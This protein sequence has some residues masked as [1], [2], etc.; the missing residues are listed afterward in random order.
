MAISLGINGNLRLAIMM[1]HEMTLLALVPV[2]E[3]T[4]PDALAAVVVLHLIRPGEREDDYIAIILNAT[5]CHME[6]YAGAQE[7]GLQFPNEFVD[8]NEDAFK[9]MES[10]MEQVNKERIKGASKPNKQ[11]HTKKKTPQLVCKRLETRQSLHKSPLGL[12]RSGE[13]RKV[14][15]LRRNQLSQL[16]FSKRT[17]SHPRQSHLM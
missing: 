15:I 1:S 8:D 6:L 7:K 2:D 10:A 16:Q 4:W 5:M 14:K 12:S 17:T 3:E 13:H 9:T 11:A